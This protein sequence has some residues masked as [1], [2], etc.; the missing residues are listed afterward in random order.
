M[1]L[2][3]HVNEYPTSTKKQNPEEGSFYK[4][5]C[6]TVTGEKCNVSLFAGVQADTCGLWAPSFRP[7]THSNQEMKIQG[8]SPISARRPEEVI[9]ESESK[10]YTNDIITIDHLFLQQ[11]YVRYLGPEL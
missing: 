10:L 1:C 11:E 6:E 3:S 2:F 7:R 5:N 4:Q 8:G 9:T